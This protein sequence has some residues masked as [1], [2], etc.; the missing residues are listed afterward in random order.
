MRTTGPET[1]PAHNHW[2]RG[3]MASEKGSKSLKLSQL[4]LQQLDRFKTQLNEV[5]SHQLHP[6]LRRYSLQQNLAILISAIYKNPTLVSLSAGGEYSDVIHAIFEGCSNE[7]E[8]IEG[9]AR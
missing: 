2:P 9:G 7:T 4:S 1:S 5:S 3:V 8:R 6:E